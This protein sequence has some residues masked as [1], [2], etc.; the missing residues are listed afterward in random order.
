MNKSAC[1]ALVSNPFAKNRTL[2][3]DNLYVECFWRSLKQ[4]EVY[5]HTRE[6]VAEAE[7]SIADYLRYFN[8]ERPYQEFD[9][10]T[11]TMYFANENSCLKR[12]NPT[13]QYT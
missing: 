2:A 8:K 5:R 4:E 11:P 6:A 10:R 13:R 3:T 1:S 12:H 7:K 9:N